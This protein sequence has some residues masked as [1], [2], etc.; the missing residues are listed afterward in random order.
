MELNPLAHQWL[1]QAAL[2][3]DIGRGDITSN[4]VIAPDAVARLAIKARG[5]MVVCGLP[6]AA[7]VFYSVNDLLDVQ[8][9]VTDGHEVA[10]GTSLMEISGN[11]RAILS[12]ERTALNFLMRMC[13]V[14]TL[15][16]QYVK[17]LEGTKTMLL[18]T[19]KT[20]PGFR[21]LDKYAVLMGGG[22]NHRLR[23][24]DGILI[25]DN[26]LAVAG[27]IKEAVARAKFHTPA[28]IRV[29]V[30]CDSIEQVKEALEAG[31]DMILL[32]NMNPQQL[33]EAVQL[34]QGRVLFEASGNMSLATVRLAAQAGVDYISVGRITHSAPAVDIGMDFQ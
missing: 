25:K 30:E 19:R 11:A 27:S 3:E 13:G 2:M 14:A 26:H 6:L 33:H 7:F 4:A 12:A 10:A 1:V 16:R 23:L 29:E 21:E 22:K 28:T 18:D 17:A 32:D 5:E 8:S 34:G 20:M 9:L 24:D 31:A 15:T